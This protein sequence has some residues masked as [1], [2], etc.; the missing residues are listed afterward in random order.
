MKQ[1]TTGAPGYDN[2]SGTPI[3]QSNIGDK[4]TYF[5]LKS[6]ILAH[7]FLHK[8]TAVELNRLFKTGDSRKYVSD[9]RKEGHPVSDFRLQDGTNRKVYFIHHQNITP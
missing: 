8:A 1:T 4:D 9:L 6:K 2:P 3:N 5:Y 7:L